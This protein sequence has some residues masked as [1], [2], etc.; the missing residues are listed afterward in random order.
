MRTSATIIFV[1]MRN[2]VAKCVKTLVSTQFRIWLRR[3]WRVTCD[4][5]RIQGGDLGERR[6]NGSWGYVHLYLQLSEKKIFEVFV[7]LAKD[8]SVMRRENAGKKNAKTHKYEKLE[9]MG[10]CI[11]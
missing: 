4:N 11:E 6:E 9:E 2:E 5:C 3:S 10:R 8:V 7:D 1:R